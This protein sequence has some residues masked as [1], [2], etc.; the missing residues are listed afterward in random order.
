MIILADLD[1]GAVVL[2]EPMVFTA[3]HVAVVGGS[4]D[5]PRLA[6][7]LEPYGRLDGGHAWVGL[8]A[9]VHL[10]GGAADEAWHEGFGAMVDHARSKSFPSDDGTSIRA[11]L[12][13]G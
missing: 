2:E 12:E 8:D 4:L 3:F 9:V 6:P 10:A 5:D 1:A 7:L 11:H 13:P